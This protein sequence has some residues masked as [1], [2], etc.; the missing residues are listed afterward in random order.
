[1]TDHTALNGFMLKREACE[2]YDRSLRQL[3]RDFDKAQM[4][5][6]SQVLDNFKLRLEDGTILTA[7][8]VDKDQVEKFRDK[9]LNPAWLVRERWMRN[10]YGV[11]DEM[12]SDDIETPVEPTP[13]SAQRPQASDSE[14]VAMKD[15]LIAELR[16]SNRF[17]RESLKEERIESREDRE[18]TKQLHILLKNLQD[19][20]LPEP[21][22]TGGLVVADRA[23]EKT[24]NQSVRAT[25]VTS[26]PP[27]ATA[28]AEPPAKVP[29]PKPKPAKKRSKKAGAQPARK[30]PRRKTAKKPKRDVF[31][32]FKRF[33]SRS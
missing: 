19:R 17:L 33:F 1:M 27:P 12:E 26:D 3:S 23:T 5:E 22:R 18:L 7:A 4:E 10:T 9:G 11:R 20:L 13:E 28:P 2:R 16:E 25:V 6:D 21:D 30:K 24:A 15:D 14:I 29:K 32:T 8:E 31:P